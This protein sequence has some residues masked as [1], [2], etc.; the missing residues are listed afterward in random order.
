MGKE[1]KK[2]YQT[3]EFEDGYQFGDVFRTVKNAVGTKKKK[4]EKQDSI[5]KSLNSFSHAY[6]LSNE[7]EDKNYV[8]R[9][10]YFKKSNS[11][12]KYNNLEE[13]MIIESAKKKSKFGKP[14]TVQ[15]YDTVK[16]TRTQLPEKIVEPEN[17]SQ[18]LN[19]IRQSIHEQENRKYQGLIYNDDYEFSVEKVK[20][21]DVGKLNIKDKGLYKKIKSGDDI[22]EYMTEDE[23][24]RY[25][26]LA[27]KGDNE[28]IRKYI[29]HIEPY[30]ESRKAQDL[31]ED[32]K[33]KKV[34]KFSDILV[35]FKKI[36][37]ATQYAVTSGFWGTLTNI[38]RGSIISSWDN[39]IIN[40][41][42]PMMNILDT[43]YQEKLFSSVKENIKDDGFLYNLW[44]DG[45][46]SFSSQIPDMIMGFAGGQIGYSSMM[47]L[48][49]LGSN[50]SQ[51]VNDGYDVSKGIE[52]GSVQIA[53]ELLP[54]LLSG[55][56]MASFFDD[57]TTD[58]TKK[59]V[60]WCNEVF[61]NPKIA[62]A[63][64]N[65]A[66]AISNNDAEGKQEFYQ[67]MLE[68]VIRNIIYGE[69]NKI[70]EQTFKD[71]L[72]GYLVCFISTAPMSL[73]NANAEYNNLN[74]ENIGEILNDDRTV[75]SILELARNNSVY[76]KEYN[77]VVSKVETGNVE[78]IDNKVLGTLWL[79]AKEEYTNPS[80]SKLQEIGKKAV[81]N[82]LENANQFDTQQM[83]KKVNKVCEL[84]SARAIQLGSGKQTAKKIADNI[85]GR[86]IVDEEILNSD[87]AR[88]IILELREDENSRPDWVEKVSNEI[89]KND[90]F[91]K[92]YNNKNIAA[93]EFINGLWE[94]APN[95]SRQNVEKSQFESVENYDENGII[96][97]KYL[98][99]S[100][101]PIDNTDSVP[102]VYS[103]KIQW[104]I[105]K[106]I[107]VRPFGK[108]FFGIR[109]KQK[110]S[111]V[112]A[113]EVKIN[114][115]KESYYLQHP[116]GRYVQFENMVDNVLQDGKC[117]LN[118]RRSFYHVYDKGDFAKNKVLQQANR[119]IE[120]ANAVG[121]KVEWL[122]SD[123]KAVAQLS[124]LFKENNV[125]IT[126]KYYPE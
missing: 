109:I 103:K 25:Y 72:Y 118:K 74:V 71:S 70:D 52:F 100:K 73:A 98:S 111:R 10:S 15:E 12:E 14:L 83:R 5:K 45:V 95:G 61:K 64:S 44:I 76:T 20:N 51:A 122:V 24:G 112:D 79:Q 81:N 34:E 40:A 121:Y 32:V 94:D 41:A 29:L 35:N 115:N 92:S 84:I 4:V 39:G 124:R 1:K 26:Y 46:N 63:V 114:S 119:Q 89:S 47:S 27:S 42:D 108:G 9:G 30:L 110:N 62:K 78:A 57:G 48:G 37:K 54:D 125:D 59:T 17:E 49:V 53:M 8:N 55:T 68:P 58:Y 67:R 65:T 16:A 19:L 23:R 116:D 85:S 38:A 117:V 102:G 90:I 107:D 96:E 60:K 113:Y 28:E 13:K 7:N 93:E 43:T 99:N 101:E 56:G 105:H 126:V 36:N 22:Y 50:M 97:D 33:L 3:G 87:I 11:V 120:S 104:S 80:E 18:A 91:G 31:A 69:A 75:N 21:S 2:W 86:V 6:Q 106:N 66:V 88:Q 123:E 82:L 77:E